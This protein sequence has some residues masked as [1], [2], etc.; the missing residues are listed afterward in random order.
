MEPLVQVALA[1]TGR[2][3]A[4]GAM[5]AN[6]AEALVT[7]QAADGSAEKERQV[8]LRAGASAVYR[9]AGRV[10]ERG[11]AL[12]APAPAETLPACSPGAARLCAEMFGHWQALVLPEALGRLRR[13][14]LR[15]PRA[16]LPLA[17][18]CGRKDVRPD[19]AVVVGERGRWLARFN[20]GWAWVEEALVG[21][22]PG[23]PAD[24]ET[25][26]EEGALPQRV[27]VLRRVR[28]VDPARGREWVEAAWPREKADARK[29]MVE[30][31]GA[32]LSADDEPFLERALDDKGGEVRKAAA[33]LL[34]R[35]PGSAY[36]GRMAARADALLDYAPSSDEPSDPQ[37]RLRAEPPASLPRDWQR[38]GIDPKSAGGGLGDRVSWL[39]GLLSV[40][41]PAHW[42][43]RFGVA[44]AVLVAAGHGSRR[45]NYGALE[46][47]TWGRTVLEGWVR[48]TIACRDADWALP[49]WSWCSEYK[50]A[51]NVEE[52]RVASLLVSLTG[53]LP[54]DEAERLVETMFTKGADAKNT[55]WVQVLRALPTP[56]SERFGRTYLDALRDY[57][58]NIFWVEGRD[59]QE[60]AETARDTLPY[61]Y[62]VSYE[63]GAAMTTAA[64]ALPSSLFDP[65]LD[66]HHF[67][68]EKKHYT[69]EWW[70]RQVNEF[71]DT[72]RMRQQVMREIS[73]PA[74]GE[75]R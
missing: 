14:G 54:R 9:Q 61:G 49:L 44:P 2:G 70:Q 39:V 6:G 12:P 7:E 21:A 32:D 59:Q 57:L 53:I 55:R 43:R 1:G 23:I 37:G 56:W 30:A 42:S 68:P 11:G 29:E 66:L 73:V 36:A 18:D 60:R 45:G 4:K 35:L 20:P 63:W 67:L 40:V 16:L 8:L 72:I 15:L 58:V 17:L 34:A 52:A 64:L 13:A 46:G 26:W 5:P 48:A 50:G 10:V 69:I 62:P 27:A 38:D 41:P 22:A 51:D 71:C 19:L 47:G 28:G 65:S 31:L 75:A 74:V 3:D 25:L 33:S 24:A